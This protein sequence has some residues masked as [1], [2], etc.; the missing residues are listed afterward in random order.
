[1]TG[2]RSPRGKG[3]KPRVGGRDGRRSRLGEA[4]S[5]FASSVFWRHTLRGTLTDW[6]GS[7]RK[8]R[9]HR[10]SSG[11]LG[12]RALRA[13]CR[14]VAPGPRALGVGSWGPG[15]LE[16]F[17]AL[18]REDAPVSRCGG[19]S[20]DDTA[21]GGKSQAAVWAS[22]EQTWAPGQGRAGG[23]LRSLP[24]EMLRLQA[25]PGTETGLAL[26]ILLW[27]LLAPEFP[28]WPV[29]LATCSPRPQRR[30]ACS[31]W[32]GWL[33]ARGPSL[34][35]AGTLAPRTAQTPR[36]WVPTHPV[37]DSMQKGLWG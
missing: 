32:L 24:T 7:S 10:A 5:I 9:V 21:E 19:R 18:V 14:P 26:T 27:M 31:R 2:E 16:Q 1:M 35:P 15:W 23:S 30:A 33:S 36:A 8:S 4:E 22:A 12:A 11:S 34:G 29:I 25:Q 17:L 13:V 6:C 37:V 28:F 3:M 20:R